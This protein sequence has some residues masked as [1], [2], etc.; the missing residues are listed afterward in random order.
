MPHVYIKRD[1]IKH[2]PEVSIPGSVVYL[3]IHKISSFNVRH[4]E[5]D[6][7]HTMFM[8]NSLQHKAFLC[9]IQNIW[10]FLHTFSPLY[11]VGPWFLIKEVQHKIWCGIQFLKHN[12]FDSWVGLKFSE[13]VPNQYLYPIIFSNIL[14]PFWHFFAL[15][16]LY[17]FHSYSITVHVLWYCAVRLWV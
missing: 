16:Y 17:I 7:S 8:V 15:I 3:T 11:T 4:F 1:I 6:V 9:F 5:C 12:S 10:S 13:G 2:S 14:G